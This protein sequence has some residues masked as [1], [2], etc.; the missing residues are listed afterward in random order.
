[1]GVKEKQQTNTLYKKI[2]VSIIV[3]IYN[4]EKYLEK[5]IES[6]RKQTYSYLEIILVND[7]STDGSLDICTKYQ[8]LDSRI[9]VISQRNKGLV[10]SRKIGLLHAKG[11]LVSFVDSDDWIEPDM[12]EQMVSIYEEFHPELISTGIYR[13]YENSGEHIVV[14]DH[15][16]EGLYCNLDADIYPTMLRNP[17]KKDFGLYCTLVNKLYLRAVLLKIYEKINTEVFFGEDCMTLYQYCL[18]INSIYISKKSFYHYN[19]RTGS[20]CS[21]KDERLPYNTYLLY[22]ELKKAFLKYH[23]PAILLKQL[24][25]YILEIEAHSLQMLYDINLNVLGKWRFPYENYYDSKIVIYGAGLCG[26][27]FYH[28]ISVCRKN[29]N[30]VAWIDKDYKKK[31]EQ[32]LYEIKSPEILPDLIYDFIII[33]VLDERLADQ[34]RNRLV[35]IY[36]INTECIIWKKVWHE[37]FLDEI[38]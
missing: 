11:E 31:L 10:C 8:K 4:T 7:G 9:S 1:M 23:T 32:C 2:K 24:R 35:D 12:Y 15:Y 21:K 28:Q 36:G 5:C 33:A 34:I 20:M 6:I 37:P 14:Y 3:P 27:A 16:Q 17:M 38:Y 18:K 29:V 26:Q 22:E 19:I 13:D 25:R 30:I